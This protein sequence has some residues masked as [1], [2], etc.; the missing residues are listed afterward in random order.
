MSTRATR[1][2]EN[3]ELFRMGNVRLNDVVD[4]LVPADARLPFLCE[5]ADEDCNGRVELERTRWESVAARAHH[6]VMVPGHAVTDGE[7]VVGSV[8]GFE[9]VRKPA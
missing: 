2:A 8:E 6:F 7:L 4:G 3:Q 1:R 9:I 5:C